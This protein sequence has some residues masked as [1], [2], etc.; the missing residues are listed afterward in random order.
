M[1]VERCGCCVG[2]Q[3]YGVSWSVYLRQNLANRGVHFKTRNA[4]DS[5]HYDILGEDLSVAMGMAS[6]ARDQGGALLV[7]CWGGCN[8]APS[9]AVAVLM[10]N[11]RLDIV[12][13]CV[14]V[15]SR[16][17]AIL[18]NRSFRR[19]LVMLAH[20]KMR[21]PLSL[22][23]PDVPQGVSGA[24]RWDTSSVE[25]LLILCF[26]AT[27]A[28]RNFSFPDSTRRTLADH[29]ADA[30][31]AQRWSQLLVLQQRKCLLS[32]IMQWTSW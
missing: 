17:G 31:A 5:G 20:R 3:V 32:H 2:V 18:S 9:I 16:R 8:R 10:L 1:R 13:A 12:Q 7:N 30:R 23:T 6:E 21:L 27:R 24:Y 28:G 29:I 26:M 11:S 25:E 22:G 4:D 14:R 15:M 19:R